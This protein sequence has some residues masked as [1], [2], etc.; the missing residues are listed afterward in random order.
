MQA[1]LPEGMRTEATQI[2]FSLSVPPR[3]PRVSNFASDSESLEQPSK[4]KQ[5]SRIGP[6]LNS[7]QLL[8]HW[9]WGGE[10]QQEPATNEVLDAGRDSECRATRIRQISSGLVSMGLPRAVEFRNKVRSVAKYPME[11]FAGPACVRRRIL[12]RNDEICRNGIELSPVAYTQPLIVF[13]CEGVLE[14]GG[15]CVL[16][17]RHFLENQ[18]ARILECIWREP[19]GSRGRLDAKNPGET[20]QPSRRIAAVQPVILNEKLQ[21]REAAQVLSRG[22]ICCPGRDIRDHVGLNHDGRPLRMKAV[23]EGQWRY[24]LHDLDEFPVRSPDGKV[25]DFGER[26]NQTGAVE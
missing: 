21:V 9:N 26:A 10:L 22:L 7:V 17:L 14:I 8:D 5:K 20:C 18:P 1:A 11:G 13:R 3:E 23:N 4:T 19:L 16:E 6:G 15:E 2:A 24:V 25:T 12:P